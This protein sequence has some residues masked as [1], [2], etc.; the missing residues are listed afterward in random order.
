[1]GKKNKKRQLTE[2]QRTGLL[3]RHLW[4]DM[5]ATLGLLAVLVPLAISGNVR[6]VVAE[7][8][9]LVGIVIWIIGQRSLISGSLAS[10]GI[11]RPVYETYR[12]SQRL[13]WVVVA[14]VF[15]LAIGL[16]LYGSRM[17]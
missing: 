6:S 15:L 3:K 2:E 13:T 11:E 8:A 1:V 9:I 4:I 10:H 14:V 16:G 5:G 17:R 12:R 7:I